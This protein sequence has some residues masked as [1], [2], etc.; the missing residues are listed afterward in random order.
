MRRENP[1]WHNM[2]MSG[3]GQRSLQTAWRDVDRCE[4]AGRSG[5]DC[6][7]GATSVGGLPSAE[8]Y[9]NGLIQPV[10]LAGSAPDEP[11]LRFIF[12]LS[13]E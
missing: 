9:R 5:K 13:D 1:A 3:A 12:Q 10:G 4:N 6:R 11:A 8:G 2:P 7:C